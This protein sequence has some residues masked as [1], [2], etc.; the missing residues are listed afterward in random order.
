LDR[1]KAQ[2]ERNAL[3]KAPSGPKTVFSSYEKASRG[4]KEKRPGSIITKEEKE[5]VSD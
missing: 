5:K 1:F 2:G 4:K 3:R